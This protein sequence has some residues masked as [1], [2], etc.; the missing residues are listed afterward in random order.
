MRDGLV[1][2]V[3]LGRA[4]MCQPRRAWQAAERLGADAYFPPEYARSHPSMRRKNFPKA[5]RDDAA[6][7]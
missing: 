5:T 3:A 2:R 4:T 1:D 6:K 7:A